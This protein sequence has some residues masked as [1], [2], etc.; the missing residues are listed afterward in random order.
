M[1][2]VTQGSK[3]GHLT[4]PCVSQRRLPNPAP[5]KGSATLAVIS[6][7]REVLRRG[8]SPP[9]G[10]SGAQALD[11]EPPGSG[12]SASMWRPDGE[13]GGLEQAAFPGRGR[14]SG[15]QQPTCR[16]WGS[17]QWRQ[18][19]CRVDGQPG[20]GREV[21]IRIKLWKGPLGDEDRWLRDVPNVGGSLK[22]ASPWERSRWNQQPGLGRQELPG[23]RAPAQSCV[24]EGGPP[25]L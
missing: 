17:G 18:A 20:C 23:P 16:V 3:S 4:C 1:T 15:D 25:R 19:V 24:G 22:A 12:P 14:S 21:A 8:R 6:H 7:P 10:D 2:W 5:R 9:G 11:T 13:R